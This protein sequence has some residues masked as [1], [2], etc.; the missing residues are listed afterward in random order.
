MRHIYIII[1][2]LCSYRF[3]IFSKF[4]LNF[5][6]ALKY[7]LFIFNFLIFIRTEKIKTRAHTHIQRPRAHNHAFKHVSICV[8]HITFAHCCGG[9]GDHIACFALIASCCCCCSH[10]VILGGRN[11]LPRHGFSTHIFKINF[12]GKSNV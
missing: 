5:S 1:F 8:P 12:H 6:G 11:T 9:R 2:F 3:M 10:I 4:V 7:C